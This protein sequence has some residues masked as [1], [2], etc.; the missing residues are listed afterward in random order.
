ML[1][2]PARI[3]DRLFDGYIVLPRFSATIAT[4]CLFAATGAYGAYVGGQWPEIV[5]AVTARSGFAIDNVRVVGNRQTSEIDVLGKLGLDG[6][7]SQIGFSAEAARR[8]I[9]TLP[10]V[11]AASV[12]KVYPGTVEIAIQE[13]KPFAIWQRG[14][15]LTLIEKDGSVIAPFSGGKFA[16]LPL[17]VGAGAAS[18]APS[19]VARVN[20]FPDLSGRVKGYIRVGDRRW[21]LKFD[22]GVTVKLPESNEDAAIADLAKMDREHG[23]LSRDILAVDLRFDDRVV[24]QLTQDATTA[25][26]AALKEQAKQDKKSGRN[27]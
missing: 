4:A 18:R 7:T 10:W 26:E 17:V 8:S 3:L 15:D 25:R 9:L 12:R 5:Q 24:V 20:R 11:E 23:L 21:D 6:W 16:A 13:K 27:I 1:R 19:I 14:D 22:N 2:K